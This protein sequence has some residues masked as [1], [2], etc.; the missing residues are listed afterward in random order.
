[1]A[2]VSVTIAGRSY[3]MSCADG[4]EDHLRGLAQMVDE[5][6]AEMR[7]SFG[8]IG[9]Q[10]LTIMAAL[11]VADEFSE[12]RRRT[13]SLEDELAR[14]SAAQTDVAAA[15]ENWAVSVANALDEASVRIERIAQVM[16]AGGRR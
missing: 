13:E 12:E 2:Q 4:E 15:S 16:N 9:D 3:R 6:I 10:R 8:E 1:M 7:Q 11:T 5:K 14:R